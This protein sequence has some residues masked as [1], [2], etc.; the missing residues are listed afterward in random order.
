MGTVEEGDKSI[1]SYE[2]ILPLFMD[3][4]DKEYEHIKAKDQAAILRSQRITKTARDEARELLG[5]GTGKLALP[6][7][8]GHGSPG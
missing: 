5:T 1:T 6:D 7:A 8:L 4:L 3:M 2:L